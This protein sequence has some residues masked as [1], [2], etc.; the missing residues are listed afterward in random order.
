MSY[1]K[2]IACA[3]AVA[4]SCMVGSAVAAP[5]VLDFEGIGDLNAINNYYNGGGGTN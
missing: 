2:K 5:I 4:A 1:L 3:C